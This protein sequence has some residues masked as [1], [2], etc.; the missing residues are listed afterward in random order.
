MPVETAAMLD[1]EEARRRVLDRI[2]PVAPIELP[3]QE[4]VGCVQATDLIAEFGLPEFSSSA[5]DGFAVRASDVH[6][7]SPQSPATL[8]IVGRALIGRPPEATVGWGEAIRI[9][10]GAPIPAGADAVVPIERVVVE[11]ETVRVLEAVEFGRHV[12]PAG[13]DVRSGQTLIPAGRKLGA[14]ELALL[15]A[16][17][18]PS[19][20]VYPKVRAVVLAT[21]DELVEPG[22]PASF[23]QVR[24]ANSFTLYGALRELGA[25]PYLAGIVP[26]DVEALRD[27]LIAHMATADLFITSGG[28]SMGDRD[29]VKQAFFRRGDVEFYRVAMR[30]GMPQAF[31]MIE[32]KPFFGLP[33]NPVSVFVSFEVFVRPALLKMMGRRDLMRPEVTAEIDG[34]LEGHPEKTQFAR[35]RVWMEGG[36][37]KARSVGQTGSNLVATLAGSNGL[38]IV[39]AGSRG[40]RAGSDVRVMVFRPLER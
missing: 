34:D 5:M 27:E 30:P 7:A 1:V 39:P 14:P 20:L 21:G 24:D 4:A 38:A 8:T 16:T 32:G 25:V 9:A 13:E 36:R 6:A 17:G 37:W 2:D 11:G 26:D 10:T 40:I 35:V 12:R 3:L 28:V 18:H 29:V 22:R 19:S 31:G 15:A 33:G 23:G